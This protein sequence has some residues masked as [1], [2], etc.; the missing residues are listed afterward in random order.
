[1]ISQWELACPGQAPWELG[2]LFA[3]GKSDIALPLRGA[4]LQPIVKLMEI[5][6]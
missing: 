6:G 1:M 4:V 5:N 3:A 2:H